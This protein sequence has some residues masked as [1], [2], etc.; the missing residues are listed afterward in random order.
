[1][2]SNK[3]LASPTLNDLPIY[4]TMT[5]S[6]TIGDT[7]HDAQAVEIE[8][9]TCRSVNPPKQMVFMR[10]SLSSTLRSESFMPIHESGPCS[11]TLRNVP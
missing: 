7:L 11:F 4:E 2:G 10:N 1:M 3:G 6:I 8:L 5:S 9:S